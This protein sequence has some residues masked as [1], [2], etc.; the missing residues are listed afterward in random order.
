V[1]VSITLSEDVGKYDDDDNHR[2]F[3]TGQM[4]PFVVD[5]GLFSDTV[6]LKLGPVISIHNA[7]SN[8][9]FWNRLENKYDDTFGGYLNI[10]T[11][12]RIVL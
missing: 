9:K 12:Q 4:V 8:G 2:T 11:G 7:V 3:Y 5:I 1:S 6:Y 10:E